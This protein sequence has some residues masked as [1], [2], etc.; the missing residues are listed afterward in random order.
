MLK[1]NKKYINPEIVIAVVL[2]VAPILQHYKGLYE[3]AGFTAILIAAAFLFYKLFYAVKQVVETKT[4]TNLQK[5]RL[6][7]VI[8]ILL[9][10]GY[11]AINRGFSFTRILYAGFFGLV[12]IAIAMDCVDLK[13]VLRYAFY[14]CLAATVV[15]L[16]QYFCYYVIRFKLQVIPV[17]LLHAESERWVERSTSTKI[18][19]FYRPSGF[20][21]EPSHVFLYFFPSIAF[22]LF[23]PK[24]NIRRIISAAVLS[25]GVVLST[26]GMGIAVVAGFWAIYILLYSAKGNKK[27]EPQFSNLFT[28]RT[29]IIIAVFLCVLIVA[30]F[31]VD[32]VRNTVNR[33]FVNDSGSTAIAGRV[34]RTLNHLKKMSARDILIGYSKDVEVSEFDFNVAGFFATLFK[35]GIIGVIL[36]YW[37]YLRGLRNVNSANFWYTLVIV[38]LSFFTA[39]THGTFYMLF[40]VC[41]QMYG[42]ATEGAQMRILPDDFAGKLKNTLVSI[43]QKILLW[44]KSKRGNNKK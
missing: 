34:R 38:A 39:H 29:L 37:F 43:W 1:V 10:L 8:P 31:T 19:G 18:G 11:T 44:F 5:D 6:L 28:K 26:S 12:Y 17:K 20:F 22:L 2:A 13:R 40:F 24:T 36:S 42:Y 35:Q 27:N 41:F 25:L 15:L 9:F 23:T 30:Y 21:L 7:A 32:I 4:L 3:N 14:I 33:I 16:I